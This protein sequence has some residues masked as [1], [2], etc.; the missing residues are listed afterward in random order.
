[1]LWVKN[2]FL[3]MFERKNLGRKLEINLWQLGP[4]IESGIYF[5]KFQNPVETF[6]KFIYLFF[7]IEILII[8]YFEVNFLGKICKTENFAKWWFIK[9]RPDWVFEFKF[10]GFKHKAL[11]LIIIF[12]NCKPLESSRN[13]KILPPQPKN[14]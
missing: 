12:S 2:C 3:K 11:I 4:Y 8:F 7:L 6:M 13:R 9:Q 10:A 5:M 1:M 14:W